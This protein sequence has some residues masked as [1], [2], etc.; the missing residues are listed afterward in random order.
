MIAV[1]K[2]AVAR[3][4]EC[5][6]EGAPDWVLLI[7]QHA[8]VTSRTAVAKAIG[9]SPAVV[10]TVLGNRYRGDMDR[11]EAAVRGAYQNRNVDC[12]VLGEIS[13]ALCGIEQRRPLN[14]SSPQRVQLYRACRNGCVHS[15]RKAVTNA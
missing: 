7:A 5:W 11:V 4:A 15:N 14:T 10:S 3:I 12:P 13:A 8:D 1:P 9:Y 6:G 2:S